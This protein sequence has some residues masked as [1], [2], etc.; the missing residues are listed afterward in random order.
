MRSYRFGNVSILDDSFCFP[1]QGGRCE[2]QG[3]EC[4]EVPGSD[5]LQNS[6]IKLYWKGRSCGGHVIQR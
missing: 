6:T 4:L 2:Q 3:A 1:A 5:V